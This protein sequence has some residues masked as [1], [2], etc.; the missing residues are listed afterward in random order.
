MSA[1]RTVTILLAVAGTAAAISAPA[2]SNPRDDF[3]S[4]KAATARYHSV[5]QARAAGYVA[6]GP[7]VESPDGAMGIHFE[8]AELME[9][10]A[11]DVRR[12]EIL[13]Y[14]PG[15]HGKLK[16]IGAEYLI[17]AD[18]TASAPELF[19]QPFDGPFE[20]HHPAMEEHYELHAW[21]WADNPSGRHA[22]FNP[23][24][25]CP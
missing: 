19:G 10:P 24:L 4:A 2:G 9:D 22:P 7:C 13:L 18:Q 5:K 3:Q 20:A 1:H 14:I 11:L 6:M 15:K 8:N 21:L 16:L 25:D 12:P 17:E 23:E